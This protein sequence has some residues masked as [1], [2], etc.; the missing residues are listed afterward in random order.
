MRHRVAGKKL[1]R[2]ADQR[3]ALRRTLIT[4]LFRY[5]AIQTTEAKIE[6]IRGEAEKMITKAKRSIAADDPIKVVNARRRAAAQLTDPEIVKKLFDEIAPRYAERPGGYT[7]VRK[8][9]R[10]VGDAAPIA[11]LELIEE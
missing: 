1:S 4:D 6:A 10:R 8:L 3:L 5:G 2:T 9:G 7:S 11:L